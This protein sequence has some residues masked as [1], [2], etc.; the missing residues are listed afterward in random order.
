MKENE[1]RFLDFSLKLLGAMVGLIKLT[2]L[3]FYSS[4]EFMIRSA[5]R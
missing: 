4:H 5:M 1:M 2:G 3:G